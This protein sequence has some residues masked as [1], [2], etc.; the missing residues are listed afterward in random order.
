MSTPVA[1]P[2]GPADDRIVA[3]IARVARELHPSPWPDA[4][5]LSLTARIERDQVAIATARGSLA[6]L[7]RSMDGPGDHQLRAA[8]TQITQILA[9]LD[10]S[11]GGH[12]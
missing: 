8:G 2:P 1:V 6:A 3:T 7:A 11:I 12:R 9:D 5:V 10:D 4:A